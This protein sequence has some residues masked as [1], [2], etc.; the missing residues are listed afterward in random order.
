MIQDTEVATTAHSWW[1][2]QKDTLSMLVWPRSKS[3]AQDVAFSGWTLTCQILI[4]TVVA[5]VCA[6]IYRWLHPLQ[7]ITSSNGKLVYT[8]SPA[9]VQQLVL[10]I[11]LGLLILIPLTYFIDMGIIFALSRR[12]GG[13]GS[14]RAQCSAMLLFLVPLGITNSL[15]QFVPVIGIIA[16]IAFFFCGLYLQVKAIREIH[17]IPTSQAIEIVLI[18]L[19][20]LL[21]FGCVLAVSLGTVLIAALR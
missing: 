4:W 9:T 10:D 7:M 5:T 21:I 17:L 12:A 8:A 15:I 16:A 20:A 6:W 2:W 18:P 11:A 13:V 14:F 3:F 19:A 1:K